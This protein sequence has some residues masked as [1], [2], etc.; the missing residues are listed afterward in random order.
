MNL[1][2]DD[3]QKIAD[4]AAESAVKRVLRDMGI[5]HTKDNALEL[6]KDFSFLRDWRNLCD[7]SKKRGIA[8]AVTMLLSGIVALIIGGLYRFFHIGP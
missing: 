4:A 8:V 2:K 6:R 5:E 1:S 7:I 3:I